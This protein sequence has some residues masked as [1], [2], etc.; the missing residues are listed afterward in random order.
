MLTWMIFWVSLN[1]R[2]EFFLA[3]IILIGLEDHVVESNLKPS[4]KARR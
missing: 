2:V 4:N 3:M 1:S